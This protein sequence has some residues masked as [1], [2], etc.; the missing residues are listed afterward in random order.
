MPYKDKEE[1]KAY[2]KVYY[3]ANKEKRAAQQKAHYEANKEKVAARVKAW[4]QANKESIATTKKAWRQANKEEIAAQ[5]KA[6]HAANPEKQA[7]IKAK[8]RHLVRNYKMTEFDKFAMEEAYALA[9]QRTISTG[10]E[11]HV[12]H[13]VPVNHPDACG[14]NSAANLQVVPA[15]W[16]IS[17]GNRSM[18][19]Y[20]G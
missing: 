12:D 10:I 16:N 20:N 15:S 1:R 7:A 11:W 5:Q 8:R 14:L 4:Q 9:R 2:A 3:A 13:I 17:K 6:Y 18:A 19:I